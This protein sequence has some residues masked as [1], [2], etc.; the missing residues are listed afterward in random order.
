MH[1]VGSHQTGEH[2]RAADRG[3]GLLRQSQQ[4]KGD[5][6]DRD[7]DAHRILGGA[8]EFLDLQRL[9]DP[10]TNLQDSVSKRYARWCAGLD[11][12][13]SEGSSYPVW[14]T[15]LAER[16]HVLVRTLGQMAMRQIRTLSTAQQT[17]GETADD[18]RRGSH[19]TAAGRPVRE[20]LS[21]AS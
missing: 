21:A 3:L 7:L 15:L 2:Q 9:F 11:H 13:M 4:Q 14:E 16:Q 19:A 6:G 1:E 20:D 10:A 5:Q 12:A 17:V 18:D 8:E